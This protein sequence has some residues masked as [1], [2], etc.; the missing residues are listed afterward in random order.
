MK[1]SK[2]RAIAEGRKPAGPTPYGLAYDRATATW[3]VDPARGPIVIEILTRVAG[4]ESC[5]SISEDLAARGV[6]PPRGPWAPH[7]V[8]V[9][10]RARHPLGEWIA[11]KRQRF[12]I[13]VP[14][15]VDSDLW[16]RAQDALVRHGKRGLRKTRHVYLLEGMAVCGHCG[17][18]I[19]IRSSTRQRGYTHPAAYV[20]R[21]R[22]LARRGAR[23]RCE[24]P[25]TRTADLDALV[26][27]AVRERVFSAG[28]ADELAALF[29]ARDAD[30]R[31]WAADLRGYR[32]HLCGSTRWL[33]ARR[34]GTGADCYRR[35]PTTSSSPPQLASVLPSRG[36]SAWPSAAPRTQA[37]SVRV[38]LATSRR[39]YR[40]PS[41][42]QRRSRSARTSCGCSW[43]PA[44]SSTDWTSP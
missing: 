44:S 1:A 34:R 16:Q 35:R 30:A 11:D 2:L 43:R 13:R 18:S 32:A 9:I 17:A 25:I 27:E 3:S 22:K 7:K 36:R 33:R 19:M 4:G 24:A 12:V 31:D 37:R 29:A 26:W 41:A 23:G 28:F 8:W 40:T 38:T 14:V 21:Q 10:A 20:C 15:I 6:P 39:G 42:T 5:W